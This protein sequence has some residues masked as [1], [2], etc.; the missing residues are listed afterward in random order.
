MI[1]HYFVT[2]TKVYASTKSVQAMY[3][4]RQKMVKAEATLAKPKDSSV[5][6]G[7]HAVRPEM[8]TPS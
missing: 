5:D 4:A 6:G 7:D 1:V 2:A 8:E 3:N